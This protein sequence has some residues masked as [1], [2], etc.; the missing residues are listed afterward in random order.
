MIFFLWNFQGIIH[1]ELVTDRRVL[2]AELYFEIIKRM[3]TSFEENN[4][5]LVYR[6]LDLFLQD[7]AKPLTD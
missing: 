7:N 6:K 1:F 5:F 4:P 3:Y 2:N